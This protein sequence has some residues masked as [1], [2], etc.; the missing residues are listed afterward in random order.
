MQIIPD[1]HGRNILKM[2]AIKEKSIFLGDY[3][4]SFDIN[5]F[6]QLN[7]FNNILKFV[8]DTDSIMLIG[9]HD[10]H[11]ITLDASHR[12]SGYQTNYALNIN[13]TL[14][15]VLDKLKYCHYDKE[16]NIIYSHA[17]ITEDYVLA[18]ESKFGNIK[19]IEK[20]I[21]IINSN[22]TVNGEYINRFVSSASGGSDPYDGVTW[23]RPWRY[24]V[25]LLL[26]KTIQVVGHT[27]SREIKQYDNLFVVDTGK[28]TTSQTI[29]NLYN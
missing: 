26:E 21:D 24:K 14:N 20:L 5:V 27:H 23:L 3:F 25:P 10:S 28:V 19:T 7:Q 18:L 29:L 11:Y 8:E 6:E 13:R 9:N 22:P 15:E 4:D 17:G 12:Y 16:D 1:T 2:G